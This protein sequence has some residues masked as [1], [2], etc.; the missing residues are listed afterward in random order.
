[1][2]LVHSVSVLLPAVGSGMCVVGKSRSV[3][4]Q[5]CHPADLCMPAHPRLM[6]AGL[7]TVCYAPSTTGEEQI[8]P[9]AAVSQHAPAQTRDMSGPSSIKVTVPSL[10]GLHDVPHLPAHAL[11]APS[12]VSYTLRCSHAWHKPCEVQDSS[13]GGCRLCC[14][15]TATTRLHGS[16]ERLRLVLGCSEAERSLPAPAV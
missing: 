1:M 5:M 9:G 10:Q 6:S 2:A 4:V 13:L 8:T 16:Q 7:L 11:S 14:S 3:A 15:G 12:P